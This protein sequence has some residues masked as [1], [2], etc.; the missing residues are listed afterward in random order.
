MNVRRLILTSLTASCIVVVSIIP[1]GCATPFTQSSRIGLD[2]GND[3]CRSYVVALDSTGNFF[4]EDMIKGAII[5]AGTGAILGALTSGGKDVGKKAAIGAVAGGVAG[6]AAGYWK[7]K[8]DQDKDQAIL[9]V[10]NDLTEEINQMNKANLAFGEL[11]SCRQQQFKKIKAD[12][13][14]RRITQD[15]ATIQWNGQREYLARDIKLANMIDENMTKRGDSYNYANQQVN[16]PEQERN[17]YKKGKPQH[18][19]AAKKK[20]SDPKKRELADLSSS[21]Q[22]K[23]DEFHNTSESAKKLDKETSDPGFTTKRI[24]V[25]NEVIV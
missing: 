11:T 9:S 15:Q 16:P 22:H 10:N 13:K 18:K 1:S 4:A 12:L 8:M 5:G 21:R 25:G 24:P 7:H 14:E 23:A 3:S 6:A 20:P 2:D 17:T 19:V